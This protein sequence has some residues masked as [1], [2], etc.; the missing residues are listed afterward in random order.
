[1]NKSGR[2]YKTSALPTT[3]WTSIF[4][5]ADQNHPDFHDRLTRL[6][7]LYRPALIAY[8]VRAHKVKSHEAEELVHDFIT[9]R[10]L[11][12]GLL[13]KAKQERGRFRSFLFACLQ[14]YVRD[15]WRG[16]RRRGVV[17]EL[18]DLEVH[19]QC[20]Y[21][22]MSAPELFDV[23]WVREV[24]ASVVERTKQECEAENRQD[25]WAIFTARVLEPCLHGV[26]P[27]AIEELAAK[28][29]L[30]ATN[31]V[32]NIT[33]TGKRKFVRCLRQV[34]LEYVTDPNDVEEEIQHFKK[35]LSG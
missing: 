33:L 31:A 29:N 24:L 35:I 2:D 1:M 23:A 14:N 4:Q 25:I 26:E 15:H 22:G 28:Y 8:L 19:G 9:D 27:V 3:R 30:Q 13:S 17:T 16:Q 18:I 6:L 11:E 10:I 34:I 7:D 20:E 5:A 32:S 21:K 12:A